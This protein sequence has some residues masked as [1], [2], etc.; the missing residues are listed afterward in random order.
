MEKPY[1]TTEKAY[2]ENPDKYNHFKV[3]VIW[4]KEEM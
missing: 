1:N 4:V 2:N 3:L